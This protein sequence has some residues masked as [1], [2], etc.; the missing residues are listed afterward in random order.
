M[1]LLV[2]GIAFSGPAQTGR[3]APCFLGHG[4]VAAIGDR[5][6]LQPTGTRF[7]QSGQSIGGFSGLRDDD[8]GRIVQRVGRAIAILAG[9][10]HI[11]GEAG[12][13]FQH[14]FAGQSGMPAGSTGGNNNAFVTEQRAVGGQ[15]GLARQSPVL[16]VI[17]ERVGQGL[18]LFKNLAQHKMWK[19][20]CGVEGGRVS[21]IN[22]HRSSR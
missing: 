17:G 8:D 12:N 22:R 6:G 19:L 15:H 3:L 2:A 10:L 13:V 14:D 16:R 20:S 1:K 18:R 7:A 4:R 11:D 9:I 21:R 5:R